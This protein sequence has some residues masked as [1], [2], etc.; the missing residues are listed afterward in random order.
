MGRRQ[1]VRHLVLVQAFRGSNPFAPA[2][3]RPVRVFFTE[4]I[5]VNLYIYIFKSVL[6]GNIFLLR[7]RL[8]SRNTVFSGWKLL[9]KTV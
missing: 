3:Q 9:N 4:K 8:A 5:Y 6:D 1:V 7:G 2:I